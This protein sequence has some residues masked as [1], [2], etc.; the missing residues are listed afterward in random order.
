M[1]GILSKGN[2]ASSE[3]TRSHLKS[4]EDLGVAPLADLGVDPLALALRAECLLGVGRRG[5]PRLLP[6]GNPPPRG[7][8]L[9]L[10]VPCELARALPLLGVCILTSLGVC[11][12]VRQGVSHKDMSFSPFPL[13]L[14]GV[15]T[16][17]CI[18]EQ[19]GV[20]AG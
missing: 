13:S 12:G 16:G 20:L 17:D 2:S 8:P 19:D 15:W 10:G 3:A 5:I 6:V 4:L 18:A 9:F 7:V 11:N 14:L 1:R